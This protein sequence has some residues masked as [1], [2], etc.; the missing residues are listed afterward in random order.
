MSSGPIH[1]TVPPCV[2]E[3]EG[4]RFEGSEVIVTRPKSARRARPVWS[5]RILA[6]TGTEVSKVE[7]QLRSPTTYALE[8]PVDHPLAMDVDQPP[9]NASQLENCA[10]I[11]QMMTPG[12]K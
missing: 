9:S 8:I 3:L 10:V 6:L 7:S 4:K 11:S 1:R 12:T 5:I 2:Y